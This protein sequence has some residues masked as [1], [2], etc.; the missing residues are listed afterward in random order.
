MTRRE[1]AALLVGL[2]LGA[3]GALAFVRTPKTPGTR[4]APSPAATS[5]DS[6]AST[7]R[8]TD[9]A[10]LQEQLR[11]LAQRKAELA[12]R[13]AEL[14]RRRAQLERR[15]AAASAPSASTPPAR[16]RFD[17]TPRDWAELAKTSSVRFCLPNAADWT[18]QTELLDQLGLSR[19]DAETI[20]RA[21][22]R[23]RLRL[24]EAL[25]PLCRDLGDAGAPEHVMPLILCADSIVNAAQ[26]DEDAF[27]EARREVAEMRAGI[28]PLP[29]ADSPP[30]PVVRVLLA[31][32][33]ETEALVQDLANDYGPEQ[34][35][36]IVY[37]ERGCA[38]SGGFGQ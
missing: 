37:R 8:P 10:K 13:E 18:K 29:A 12:Q 19:K 2:V 31:V 4:A 23:S 15:V 20:D 34:A 35:R 27:R 17:L 6:P 11:E 25:S 33:G 26:R 5:D 28:R 22:A 16:S 32:T 7:A 36:R 3:A 30:S 9:R 1:I 14:E 38:W 21:Y 24:S